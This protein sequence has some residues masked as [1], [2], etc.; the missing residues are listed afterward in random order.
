MVAAA[1]PI[2]A[3][4]LRPIGSPSIWETGIVGRC[5]CTS[6]I[7]LRPVTTHACS[8]DMS[9]STRARDSCII[10]LPFGNGKNCLGKLGVLSGHSRVPLPPARITALRC[11]IQTL[12][13]LTSN[14]FT[15]N[16]APHCAQLL[17]MLGLYRGSGI[18]SNGT[19]PKVTHSSQNTPIM[20]CWT[21]NT[22]PQPF[23]S[24]LKKSSNKNLEDID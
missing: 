3:A 22:E 18:V 15:T 6:S 21:N 24:D 20:V 16:R 13:Y 14:I 17:T 19:K 11:S 10:L 8:G 9:P 12:T 1:Q 7:I 4:V 5:S 23:K 2:A